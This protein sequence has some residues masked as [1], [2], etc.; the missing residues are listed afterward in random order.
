M[1]DDDETFTF[2]QLRR[3]NPAALKELCAILGQLAREGTVVRRT[4]SGKDFEV[5]Q[6]T[7]VV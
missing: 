2:E 7:K 6:T 4:A 5:I 1:S 3:G